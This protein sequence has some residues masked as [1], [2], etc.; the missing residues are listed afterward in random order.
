MLKELVQVRLQCLERLVE[1]L[2]EGHSIELVEHRFVESLADAVGLRAVGFRPGMLDPF[3]HEI[4]L[5]RVM[6][7]A[8]AVF[9]AA[10]G[11][12]SKQ[13]NAMV[14][15]EGEHPVVKQIRSGDRRLLRVQLGERDLRVDRKSVV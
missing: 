10:I 13:W 15:E 9:T 5:K 4:Q 1:V 12:N 14:R 7:I 11:K 6:F 3:D 2:P 8:A